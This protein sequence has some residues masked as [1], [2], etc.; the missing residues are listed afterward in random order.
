MTRHP[1]RIGFAKR[2]THDEIAIKTPT[3]PGI[4]GR[5]ELFEYIIGDREDLAI[6]TIDGS[7]QVT[8]SHDG[9]RLYLDMGAARYQMWANHG[10]K[11]CEGKMCQA[12]VRLAAPGD[13]TIPIYY[14]ADRGALT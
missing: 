5:R 8:L 1:Q 2:I 11:L 4:V 12:P 7:G 3:G 14:Q 6:W 13:S 10:R 9:N